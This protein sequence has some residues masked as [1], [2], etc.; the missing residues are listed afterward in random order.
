MPVLSADKDAVILQVGS[1]PNVLINA[2]AKR[3]FSQAG[4]RCHRRRICRAEKM[5]LSELGRSVEKGISTILSPMSS[6]TAGVSG[7]KIRLF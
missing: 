3:D 7:K 6:V 2:L 4:L 1:V 5:G